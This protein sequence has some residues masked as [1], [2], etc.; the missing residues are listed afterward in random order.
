M[1]N[2]YRSGNDNNLLSNAIGG[3]PTVINYFW[4][5]YH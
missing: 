1:Y 4:S 2:G 3:A 5:N